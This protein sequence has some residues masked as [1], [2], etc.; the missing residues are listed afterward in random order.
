[1]HIVWLEIQ[2]LPK[3]PPKIYVVGLEQS[4]IIDC[5]LYKMPFFKI[6]SVLVNQCYI[7]EWSIF[8]LNVMNSP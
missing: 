6:K 3:A 8:K 1:M 5:P 4:L 2:N 7:L